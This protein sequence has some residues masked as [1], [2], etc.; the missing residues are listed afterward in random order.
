MSTEREKKYHL[1][2]DQYA[3]KICKQYDLNMPAEII[4]II[5]MFY[6][7]KEINI[8]HGDR[9]KVEGN[10]VTNINYNQWTACLNKSVIDDWMDPYF[11]INHIHT[12]KIKIIKHLSSE[13]VI[14]IVGPGYNLNTPI[15]YS[16]LYKLRWFKDGEFYRNSIQIAKVDDYSAG[17]IIALTLNLELLS[18]SYSIYGNNE[19]NKPQKEGILISKGQITKGKYKWAVEI[20]GKD[21]CVEIID[22]Y[23]NNGL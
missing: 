1:I 13:M 7:I 18:L 20:D 9:I 19:D 23:S 11:D 10:K 8:E 4:A 6:F 15:S 3:M 12:I 16:N 17:W 5:F 2:T 14:G 21:D 22:I